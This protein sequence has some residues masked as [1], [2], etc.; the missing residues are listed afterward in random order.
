MESDNDS[1]GPGVR[2]PPPIIAFSVIGL[3]YGLEQLLP[4]PITE[5][6]QILYFGILVLSI[7]IIIIA[8]AAFSFYRAKTHIE[9]WKPTTS[10]IS[11]GIFS[12]SRNPIYLAFCLSCPGFGLIFNSWWLVLSCIP[13]MGL[14]YF[15]V[16]RLEEAY[17]S[18][19]F[20]EEYLQYMRRVRRWL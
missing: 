9:P 20:G 16:I 3:A 1:K 13:L 10:I 15:L 12:L 7:S 19:K 2:I 5:S 18:H 6:S 4:L 11:Q 8:I 17:L 14:L